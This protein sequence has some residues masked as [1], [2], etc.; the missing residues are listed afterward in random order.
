VSNAPKLTRPTV[1]VPERRIRWFALVY[2]WARARVGAVFAEDSSDDSCLNWGG[3]VLTQAG[4]QK[5]DKLSVVHVL[6]N[7]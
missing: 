2:R 6:L 3:Q 5:L 7:A 4:I 1:E